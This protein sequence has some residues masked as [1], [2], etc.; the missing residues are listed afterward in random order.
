MNLEKIKGMFAVFFEPL[1]QQTNGCQFVFNFTHSDFDS[2]N[3][4]LECQGFRAVFVHSW[5]AKQ[6]AQGLHGHLMILSEDFEIS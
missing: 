3:F 5:L 1:E 6:V 2:S 4:F